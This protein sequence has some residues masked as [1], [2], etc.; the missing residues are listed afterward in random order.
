MVAGIKWHL[1]CH[2]R[3]FVRRFG[4]ALGFN[5]ERY[6]SYHSI[7]REASQLSN[8]QAPSRD[9][10]RRMELQENLKHIISGGSYSGKDGSILCASK[11]VG[12]FIKDSVL[13]QEL[14]GLRPA[15]KTPPSGELYYLHLGGI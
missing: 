14:Y 8:R 9:I 5:E 13:F 10:G 4:P 6:E 3:D 7:V 12:D 1:L 15:R 2:L 11:P